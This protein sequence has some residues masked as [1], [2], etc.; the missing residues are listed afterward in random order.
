MDQSGFIH[1]ALYNGDHSALHRN[2]KLNLNKK[3]EK[4]YNRNKNLENRDIEPE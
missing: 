3:G 4:Y 2:I 1:I